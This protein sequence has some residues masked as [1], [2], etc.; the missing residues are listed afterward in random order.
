M[1][2]PTD[3]QLAIVRKLLTKLSERSTLAGVL[4]SVFGA[5][6]IGSQD[7]AG[8]I[9]GYVSVAA[10]V[11]L[12]LMSDKTLAAWLKSPAPA[13]TT[14]V[15][16]PEPLTTPAPSAP[17][18]A[19]AQ[20]MSLLSSVA[21]VLSHVSPIVSAAY[22]AVTF[23][24]AAFP[25]APGVAKLQSAQAYVAKA[26]GTVDDVTSTIEGVLAALKAQGVISSSSAPA[27]APV[28]VPAA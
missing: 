17:S 13:S 11:G 27:S 8:Q 2:K 9:A 7:E 24:E 5:M 6:G 26:V 25:D 10:S 21:G 14:P 18:T 23:V 4:V 12:V 3:A 1:I 19:E 16:V 15:T 22:Q 20:P 28:Q